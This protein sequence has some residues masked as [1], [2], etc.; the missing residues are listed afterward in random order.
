[1]NDYYFDNCKD[2]NFQN[3]N[4]ENINQNI[5][6]NLELLNNNYNKENILKNNDFEENQYIDEK[7]FFNYNNLNNE[8]EF[9]NNL[10][11]QNRIIF[12]ERNNF[13]E[14]ISS[15]NDKNDYFFIDNIDNSMENNN[16]EFQSYFTENNKISNKIDK[17]SDNYKLK[18]NQKF[19]INNIFSNIIGNNYIQEEGLIASNLPG[20]KYKCNIN[21]IE[22]RS[23]YD[24]KRNF[25]TDY[26]INKSRFINFNRVNKNKLS[27]RTPNYIIPPNKKRALSQEN[28]VNFVQKYYDNN[29]IIEEDNE[30]E[31][32]IEDK[33]DK[34]NKKLNEENKPKNKEQLKK[35]INFK[36][37]QIF[38]NHCLTPMTKINNNIF[39]NN[40]NINHNKIIKNNDGKININ[41]NNSIHNSNENKISNSMERKEINIKEIKNKINFKINDKLN[42]KY[43]RF[44]KY[45]LITKNIKNELER[46]KNEMENQLE[47][48]NDSKKEEKGKKVKNNLTDNIKNKMKIIKLN[49]V[50]NILQKNRIKKKKVEFPNLSMNNTINYD[51]KN[52]KFDNCNKTK[53]DILCKKFNKINKHSFNFFPSPD[54][55][56]NISNYHEHVIGGKIKNIRNSLNENRHIKSIFNEKNNKLRNYNSQMIQTYN[57][58]NNYKIK[59]N[60]SFNNEKCKIFDLKDSKLREFI[61]RE[62][63][64][65]RNR[66]MKTMS[67]IRFKYIYNAKRFNEI[68]KRKYLKGI[69]P[70]NSSL[71]FTQKKQHSIFGV[72]PNLIHKQINI[73]NIHSINDYTEIKNK[74]SFSKKYKNILNTNLKINTMNNSIKNMSQRFKSQTVY[75][76]L[77]SSPFSLGKTKLKTIIKNKQKNNNN[78]TKTVKNREKYNKYKKFFDIN[79]NN[80]NFNLNSQR[81]I[82]RMSITDSNYLSEID[83]NIS[84][85]HKTEIKY[86][87]QKS[88]GKKSDITKTDI[89]KEKNNFSHI[90]KN[91]IEKNYLDN[92]KKK[93][94]KIIKKIGENKI[95]NNS[96][97]LKDKEKVINRL[98]KSSN[99]LSYLM[100]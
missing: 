80:S 33:Y 18:I 17:N 92:S 67:I 49:E 81:K 60:S 36:N 65:S 24:K 82:V 20:L 50:K 66:K 34:K 79:I 59:L 69:T 16:N 87:Q 11:P 58:K 73:E 1:M 19:I 44:K 38:G 83:T 30:E 56:N 32:F 5:N 53:N 77:N 40:N 97:K 25:T 96:K 88:E 100:K 78:Y 74:N 29:F 3:I 52:I 28:P 62:F 75:R 9:Q 37:F 22:K 23:N 55:S 98:K 43:L 85:N 54:K 45:N 51:Y 63:N 21:N 64:K 70:K 90:L 71:S 14:I 12:S 46:K 84:Q 47:K 76:S 7:S 91:K 13:K 6:N 26:K 48:L 72:N 57:K 31:T 42:K 41:N 15:Y 61:Q 10:S 94:N 27:I 86:S 95:L 68:I 35:N 8:S 2:D 39:G 4:I 89:K 93:K 99:I